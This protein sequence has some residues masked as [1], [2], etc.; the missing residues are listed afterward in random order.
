[1]AS[2]LLTATTATITL[3]CLGLSLA[4][5]A[6]GWRLGCVALGGSLAFLLGIGVGERSKS[7]YCRHLIRVNALLAEQLRWLSEDSL[8][9]LCGRAG[10][11]RGSERP[12]DGGPHRLGARGRTPR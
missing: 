8:D 2:R 3:L 6:L 5:I 11:R 10:S 4:P 1:M 7:A 12:T 9:S